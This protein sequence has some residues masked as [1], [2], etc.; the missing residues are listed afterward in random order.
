MRFV[1]FLLFP[2]ALIYD[3]VTALRNRMFDVGL[4]KSQ[5]F[6]VPTVVVGNLAVGGTGKTPFVEFLINRLSSK[7]NLSVL[8][9]G[10]GRKTHGYRLATET[11]SPADIG[12]EPFQIYS[13]YKN[14]VC[15]AVGEERILAIPMILAENPDVEAIVL[16]DA[17]QHRYLAADLNILLTTYQKPFFSDYLL[18]MGRLRE[19]RKNVNRADIIVFT[20]CPQ[21]LSEKDKSIYKEK[22]AAYL[23]SAKPIYFAGL[24]YGAPY[25]LGKGDFS[26][27]DNI[28]LVTGIVDPE[29]IR[30]A[31]ENKGKRVLEILAFPDHY[32]YKAQDME[33]IKGIYKIHS[34]KNVTI[35]TTEKDAV[36]L[37]DNR[38]LELIPDI[39]VFVLPVEVE[40]TRNEEEQLL[41]RVESLIINKNAESEI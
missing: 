16:D 24:K 30:L 27:G 29:P 5:P 6:E 34:A 10:Y 20:K 26:L 3:G 23:N 21:N 31:L 39:P 7:F 8:S 36:K 11:S 41:N 37:K 33:K 18:P 14:K 32:A 40:M 4:K 13:K 17:F 25:A 19:G 35:L 1:D 9:R 2:F 38:L 22:T 15:V 12:D 28:I